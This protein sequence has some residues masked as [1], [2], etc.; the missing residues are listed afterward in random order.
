MQATHCTSDMYWI[1]ERLGEKRLHE[2]Y[3]KTIGAVDLNQAPSS[4]I[5]KIPVT[6]SFRWWETLDITRQP[7]NLK[8]K[9]FSTVLNTVERNITRN[10]PRILTRL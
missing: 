3:P 5:I 2:A 1:D 7:P 10:I 6:F 9:I 4:E 8:E